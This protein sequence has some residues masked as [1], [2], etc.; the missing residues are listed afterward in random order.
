M[1][2]LSAATV[3]SRVFPGNSNGFHWIYP[4]SFIPSIGGGGMNRNQ[5][6]PSIGFGWRIAS[7]YAPYIFLIVLD[8]F[9]ADLRSSTRLPPYAKNLKSIAD[10]GV[11]FKNCI[12][13]S[14]WT[15]PS[16]ASIFTG[17]YPI[18]HGSHG[19]LKGNPWFDGF[20]G[21]RP[22]NDN[23]TTLAEIFKNNSYL[24]AAIVSNYGYLQP[25]FK[26]NKGFQIYYWGMHLTPV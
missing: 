4:A 10:E 19:I 21:I 18:E 12:A 25:G 16:H 26:F 11:V 8:T 9:R 13:S 15:A 2:N 17:L 3:T 24:T 6:A 5:V 14:S 1:D 20:P 7:E 23:A 22:I